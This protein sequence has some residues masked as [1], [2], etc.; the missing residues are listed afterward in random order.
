MKSK[1]SYTALLKIKFNY[2]LLS[3][4]T[5]EGS[6]M[7]V[8]EVRLKVYLLKGIKQEDALSI[9][10]HF[11]DATLSKNNDFYNSKTANNFKNYCFDSFYPISIN[12]KYEKDHVYYVRVR[13]INPQLAEFFAA[14]LVNEYN[15]YMKALTCETRIIPKKVIEKIFTLTPAILKSG[16]GYWKDMIPVEEYITKMKQNLI[17]KFNMYTDNEIEEDAP[18]YKDVEMLNKKPIGVSYKGIILLGDKLQVNIENDPIAQE[19]AYL[20]IGTGLGEMNSRGYGFVNYRW[21]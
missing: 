11:I 1:S 5:K 16:T 10:S 9:I 17:K 7:N 13:T 18:L 4:T 15:E 12:E 6:I 2:N 14:K 3:H 20:S 8:Y 21:V 19:L